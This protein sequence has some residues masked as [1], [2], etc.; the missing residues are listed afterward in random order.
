MILETAIMDRVL[1][2]LG[3]VIIVG[4]LVWS[5]LPGEPVPESVPVLR[6]IGSGF[7]EQLALPPT[8]IN[9]AISV[10]NKAADAANARGISNKAWADALLLVVVCLGGVISIFA[11]LQKI[12]GERNAALVILTGLLGAGSAVS[13]SAA[14]HLNGVADED[15]ACV[16]KIENLARETWRRVRSES[17]PT[18]AR[19]YLTEMQRDVARCD[20]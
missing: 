6:K 4:A 3:A 7:Q 18:A 13:T 14:N 8:E 16:E 20:G 12:L 11:G 19:Q 15:F 5:V 2:V 1:I 10:A 9:D 17:D